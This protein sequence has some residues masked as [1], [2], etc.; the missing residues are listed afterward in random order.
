MDIAVITGASSGLGKEYVKEIYEKY[1]S[2]DEIWV[3][4]RRAEKLEEIKAQYKKAV[5][6][7]LDLSIDE[8]YEEYKEKLT[9][10]GATVK[11]LVNN[12]GLGILGDF[13]KAD[14]KTQVNMTDVNIKALTAL[15]CI[16]LPFM[17]KGS[18]IVN[19]CSIASFVPTPRMAVYCSTKAYVMSFS[20]ALGYE[21][22]KKGI[23]VLAVCPGPM[24]TE[25]LSVGNITGNSKTFDN[26]PRVKAADIAKKSLR[27]AE[28]GRKVYTNKVLYKFYRVLAK[29]LP[30]GLLMNIT[31]V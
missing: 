4:A 20:R 9:S 15:S 30:H 25:F 1:P 28:N 17:T 19:I 16:T 21:L 3:I 31:K 23:N 13:D 29:I 24:E 11:I 10:S 12:S 2:L 18:F 6:L 26:L 22:L 8:S 27:A 7:P 14:Y 5:V